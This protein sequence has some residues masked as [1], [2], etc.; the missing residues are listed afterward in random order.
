MIQLSFLTIFHYRVMQACVFFL[1]YIITVVSLVY[2]VLLACQA[3]SYGEN[4]QLTC[5]C[6]GAPC[7]PITGQCICPD[8]KT[9]DSCQEGAYCSTPM[10]I[11]LP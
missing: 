8:G 4:C 11:V 5:A 2:S 3:G 7:D 9:G 6:S 10:I 1:C